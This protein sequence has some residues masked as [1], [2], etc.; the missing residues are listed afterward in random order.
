MGRDGIG[1]SGGRL[2][3]IRSEG[4]ECY[5]DDGS[6]GAAVESLY[7]DG[8]GTL[9]VGAISGLWRWKPGPPVRLL[10]AHIMERQTLAQGD[11][12]SGLV[13]IADDKVRQFVG[14]SAMDYPLQGLPSSLGAVRVLRDR[15][16]SL[17]IGTN[18]SGLVH[19]Y[20]GKTS[21][22]T[23]R[24]GLSSDQVKGLFQDRE[25]TIWVATSAGLDQFHELAV[26]SLSVDEGLSSASAHSVLAARDGSVWIG[27]SDGLYRWK[28][29]TVESYRTRPH[30]ARID[31][32]ISS[33]FE[34]DDGRIWVSAW[35]GL[36]VFDE[37]EVHRG[38]VGAEGHHVRD[39]RRLSR[40]LVAQYVVHLRQ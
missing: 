17:W 35:R 3:A 24:D 1:A 15:N 2:C 14:T 26:T 10:A 12:G 37:G 21:T 19:V 29:G 30:P 20:R 38:A 4:T 11:Q 33:L 28:D 13:M 9:W 6:F 36:A 31:D 5:G 40:R 16:G 18:S 23:H 27:L 7:E 34:D 39:R 25:G 22:F 8:D 32:R